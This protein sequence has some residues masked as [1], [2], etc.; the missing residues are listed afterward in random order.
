VPKAE[1]EVH[2]KR[3]LMHAVWDRL[4]DEEFIDGS[5]NGLPIRC[6]DDIERVFFIR[7]V[8]YSADYPEK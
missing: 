6:S 8:T 2:C 5:E 1:V 7:I 4:L 3:E